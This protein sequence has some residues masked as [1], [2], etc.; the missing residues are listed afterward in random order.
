MKTK[1]LSK[2]LALNKKTIS[3]LSDSEMNN[4]HGGELTMPPKTCLVC[5]TD[6]GPYCD[7]VIPTCTESTTSPTFC[8]NYTCP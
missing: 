6:Y 1:K 2:K 8:A 7:S 3:N 4:V 5:E